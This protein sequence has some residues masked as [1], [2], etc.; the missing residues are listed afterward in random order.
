MTILEIDFRRYTAMPYAHC[1]IR[2]DTLPKKCADASVEIASII[3]GYRD[4][5]S[6]LS[7]N[8]EDRK[9]S[10]RSIKRILEI[11]NILGTDGMLLHPGQ[12]APEGRVE[13]CFRAAWLTQNI[14]LLKMRLDNKFR[15]NNKPFSQ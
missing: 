3:G 7:L 4:S 8:P 15:S 2:F 11:G 12:L 13:F 9:K 14:F 5:G 10:A 1:S 6:M